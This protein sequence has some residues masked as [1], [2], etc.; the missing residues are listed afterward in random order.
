MVTGFTINSELNKIILQNRNF[1][2]ARVDD[3]TSTVGY[4][5][6]KL[7]QMFKVF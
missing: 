7:D 4:S 3:L 5:F 6:L 2:G 1:F